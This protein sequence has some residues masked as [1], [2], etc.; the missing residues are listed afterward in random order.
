MKLQNFSYFLTLATF[1][2]FYHP[3]K[4]LILKFLTGILS[5]R[6]DLVMKVP[7]GNNP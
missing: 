5:L 1:P 4:A 2:I 3:F 6:F 7:I